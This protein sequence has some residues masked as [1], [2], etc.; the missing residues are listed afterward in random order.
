[1]SALRAPALRGEVALTDG[2]A[3]AVARLAG[4]R[5]GFLVLFFVVF[6]RAEEVCFFRVACGEESIGDT[7]SA[8]TSTRAKALSLLEYNC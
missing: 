8:A 6:L 2:C 3:G 7:A 1:M 5:A 4:L